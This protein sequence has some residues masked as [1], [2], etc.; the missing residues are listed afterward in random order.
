[1]PIP[2]VDYDIHKQD[3]VW[4]LKEPGKV[5]AKVSSP[6]KA[7]LEARRLALHPERLFEAPHP[8]ASREPLLAVNGEPQD[9]VQRIKTPALATITTHHNAATGQLQAAAVV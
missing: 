8:Q 9:I 5:K 3:R 4:Q 1:M 7:R 2:N 6:A